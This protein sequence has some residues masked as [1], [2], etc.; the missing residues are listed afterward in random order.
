MSEQRFTQPKLILVSV[1]N[2]IADDTIANSIC[3]K[4]YSLREEITSGSTLEVINSFS[5][6]Y[7]SQFKNVVVKC[8]AAVRVIIMN[9]N[10]G[11]VYFRLFSCEAF[12]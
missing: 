11:Q 8:T 1:P 12:H 4:N 2:S 10:Q 9:I 5:Q 6:K 3:D 7:R